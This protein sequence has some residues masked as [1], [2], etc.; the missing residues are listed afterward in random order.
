[1]LTNSPSFPDPRLITEYKFCGY[2]SG[3]QSRKL[4]FSHASMHKHSH[5]HK[6]I[7]TR[8]HRMGGG[9]RKITAS[10]IAGQATEEGEGPP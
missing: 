8:E 6:Y 1:M 4:A 10:L 7:Q 5:V 3:A 2:P 9:S